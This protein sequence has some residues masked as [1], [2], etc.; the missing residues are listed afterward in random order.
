MCALSFERR[1]QAHSFR[2]LVVNTCHRTERHSTHSRAEKH[3]C[4]AEL[5]KAHGRWQYGLQRCALKRRAVRYDLDRGLL[6]A[7]F[8][9]HVHSKRRMVHLESSPRLCQSLPGPLNAEAMP[10]GVRS[11][12][13]VAKAHYVSIS[14]SRWVAAAR[15]RGKLVNASHIGRAQQMQSAI[16]LLSS[17]TVGSVQQAQ[18]LQAAKDHSSRRRLQAGFTLWQGLRSPRL[19]LR[20]D[21]HDK[22]NAFALLRAHR[23]PHAG[24]ASA[25][26]LRSRLLG[27][28]TSAR[29]Q[30]KRIQHLKSGLQLAQASFADCGLRRGLNTLQ[31]KSSIRPLLTFALAERA[32]RSSSRCLALW[33]ACRYRRLVERRMELLSLEQRR[34]HLVGGA[35]RAWR[36]WRDAG[37]FA[38]SLS[39]V[40][41]SVPL[42]S[43]WRAWLTRRHSAARLD[44]GDTH[45]VRVALRR[46]GAFASVCRSSPGE[47]AAEWCVS[48]C[49]L[50]S[51][52][53]QLARACALRAACAAQLSLASTRALVHSLRRL[54]AS[55]VDFRQARELKA[56][57]S[58]QGRLV[59]RERALRSWALASSI[60]HSMLARSAYARASW[61]RWGKE[62]AWR[63]LSCTRLLSSKLLA[64]ALSHRLRAGGCRMR[65]LQASEARRAPLTVAAA[66]LH[67]AWRAWRVQSNRWA[68]EARQLQAGKSALRA[69]SAL[70]A[71]RVWR[72]VAHSVLAAARRLSLARNLSLH[73]HF[74]SLKLQLHTCGLLKG[75]ACQAHARESS[76]QVAARFRGWSRRHRLRVRTA[77]C[78]ISTRAKLR[79]PTRLLR[80]GLHAWSG[81]ARAL[82]SA[83]AKRH[84]ARSAIRREF[85]GER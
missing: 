64:R 38:Y 1:V 39:A 7:L 49:V 8:Q 41:N 60:H 29:R 81:R 14:L 30:A 79:D 54:V 65:A 13:L 28:S 19:S 59:R 68:C 77:C 80:V 61:T 22:R 46:W 63:A 82:A 26:A 53:S 47:A 42:R 2:S 57:S 44:W 16:R 74:H 85:E 83:E 10:S 76:R 45:R 34:R 20:R 66:P 12:A 70:L 72:L 33:I 25:H 55:S 9:L 75:K 69:T 62:R 17:L 3:W 67:G 58:S 4:Q 40:G 71:L 32:E 37:F 18:G 43:A 5:R 52:F 35:L 56:A 48:F 27:W 73:S 84:A 50:R 11:L 78:V 23:T 24:L 51:R 6:C 21:W 15:E 31:S 36:G